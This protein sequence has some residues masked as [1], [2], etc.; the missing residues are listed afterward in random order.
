MKGEGLPAWL[1]EGAD[2]VYCWGFWMALF[3]AVALF[4]GQLHLRELLQVWLVG[5]GVNAFLFKYT[6]H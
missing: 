5:V 4:G 3:A 2:C 1:H 6:G